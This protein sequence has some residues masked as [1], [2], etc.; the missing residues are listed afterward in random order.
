MLKAAIKSYLKSNIVS[1]ALYTEK[2]YSQIDGL[3]IECSVWSSG[4]G[5]TVT[6]RRKL[7]TKNSK[8]VKDA[9]T[10]FLKQVEREKEKFVIRFNYE[11]TPDDPS[12]VLLNDGFDYED[13]QF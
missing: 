3:Y 2:Q 13:E 12:G 9:R 10:S 11:E 5:Y 8:H 7:K 4:S 1:D 6:I